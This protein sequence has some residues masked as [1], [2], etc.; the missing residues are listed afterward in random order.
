MILKCYNQ[1]VVHQKMK[2]KSNLLEAYNI[3][4]LKLLKLLDIEYK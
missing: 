4:L 3:K 2:R 1:I